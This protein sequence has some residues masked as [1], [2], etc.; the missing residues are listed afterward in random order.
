MV[1]PAESDIRDHWWYNTWAH[2]TWKM[3]S[4]FRDSLSTRFAFI[5]RI[6]RKLWFGSVPIY[7]RYG[8]G[9]KSIFEENQEQCANKRSG[10]SISIFARDGC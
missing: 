7:G 8:N 2:C 6:Y 3:D 9:Y 10:N 4:I 5:F 1:E